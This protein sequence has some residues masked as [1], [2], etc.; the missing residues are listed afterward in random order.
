MH[1]DPPQARASASDGASDGGSASEGVSAAA[2]AWEGVSA[3]AS[4]AASAWEGLSDAG[5]EALSAADAVARVSS[6]ASGSARTSPG[7]AVSQER[8]RTP[9][10]PATADRGRSGRADPLGHGPATNPRR[11]RAGRAPRLRK[12]AGSR[13][14]SQPTPHLRRFAASPHRWSV[15]TKHVGSRRTTCSCAGSFSCSSLAI[16]ARPESVGIGRRPTRPLQPSDELA[17]IALW[18]VEDQRIVHARQPRR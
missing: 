12:V 9:D 6:R 17:R 15:A 11:R 10:V 8:V 14:L 18:Q 5:S 13:R 4:A 2:S 7:F 3:A 1:P 16:A